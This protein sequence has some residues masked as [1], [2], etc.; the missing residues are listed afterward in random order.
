MS[1]KKK[2]VENPCSRGW[3]AAIAA[4]LYCTRSN[5]QWL[6]L[7]EISKSPQLLNLPL[8]P[9]KQGLLC[10]RA[11][12]FSPLQIHG[13]AGMRTDE[14]RSRANM[15]EATQEESMVQV[16]LNELPPLSPVWLG[17]PTL[18]ATRSGQVESQNEA[19]Q[20]ADSEA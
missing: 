8:R 1:K 12:A 6:G 7:M 9:F 4:R 15:N 19:M 11:V 14:V 20:A 18:V 10:L 2:V 17:L 5:R 13:E 16:V 3:A